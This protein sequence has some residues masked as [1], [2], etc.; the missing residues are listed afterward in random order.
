MY[1]FANG[2]RK[3]VNRLAFITRCKLVRAGFIPTA[4]NNHSCLL[5]FL[6]NVDFFSHFW[7]FQWFREANYPPYLRD[8]E[9]FVT[10]VIDTL[11]R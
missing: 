1:L 4:F 8:V 10:V 6:Q 9:I 7:F 3:R 11:N 2:E 5:S